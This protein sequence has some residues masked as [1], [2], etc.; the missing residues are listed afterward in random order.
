MDNCIKAVLQTGT[1]TGIRFSCHIFNT[2]KEVEFAAD[3]IHKE[4]GK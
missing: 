3:I 2:E 4:L 1:T